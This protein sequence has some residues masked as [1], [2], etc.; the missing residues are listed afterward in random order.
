MILHG[1]RSYVSYDKESMEL[2]VFND[3]MS[4]MAEV[5]STPLED[6]DNYLLLYGVFT[7]AKA[8]P[9]QI[10]RVAP[11]IFVENREDP[12]DDEEAVGGL[13]LEV[14]F[15]D[16]DKT[17][18]LCDLIE[19]IVQQDADMEDVIP[20]AFTIDD[21]HVL[22]GDEACK[23][24]SVDIDAIDF[25]VFSEAEKFTSRIIQKGLKL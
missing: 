6:H 20:W 25:E 10:G 13:L 17:E 12:S 4:L 24:L 7:S 22:W 2:R 11:Y 14:S 8:I 1:A 9:N 19:S 23:C 5:N 16:G 18:R 21:I 3:E 15:S